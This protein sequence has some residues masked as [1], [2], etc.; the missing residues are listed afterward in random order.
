MFRL[1]KNSLS[2]LAFIFI[3]SLA[4]ISCGGGGGGSSDS[5][6]DE[7]GGGN[8]PALTDSEAVT[9]DRDDLVI[10]Y[11]SGDSAA[12]VT[13]SVTLAVSGSNGT[14]V[15]WASDN[16]TVI[17]IN[18]T[19]SRPTYNDGE[20]ATVTVTLTATI[21]KNGESDTKTFT[22]TVK[23]ISTS[24]TLSG[25]TVS[26]GILQP[27]FNSS[28]T[29][30]LDAPVPFSDSATP[31]YNDTQSASITATA[32]NS[33]A[34]ITINSNTVGSGSAYTM[35]NLA[36]GANTATIVVTAEDGVTNAT[37]VVTVYRA[38]PVFKTGQTTSYATGDDGD[39]E[40]GVSWP[41][42]RFT[43]N[44]NGTM[45]DNMTGLVWLK[46]LGT[47][48]CSWENGITYCE[49]L[50]TGGNDW[51]MPNESEFRSLVHYG[52]SQP[53]I[54]L[55]DQ[56]FSN[57]QSAYYWSSTTSA[58]DT[59]N[60]YCI[61]YYGGN[62]SYTES[63]T[64]LTW[65][66][67][68]PVCAESLNLPVSGQTIEYTTG[69]DGT[70]K[71]GVAFPSTRFRDNGDGTITD[72]MTGLM[73]MKNPNNTCGTVNSQ[74]ALFYVSLLNNVANTNNC[75]YTDWRVPNI[76][77][78]ETLVNY[79]QTDSSV[80][81]KSQGFE[82]IKSNAYWSS[83]SFSARSDHTWVVNFNSGYGY[84]T[85]NIAT[86]YVWPVRGPVQ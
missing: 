33:A 10:V 9:E 1:C 22:L 47:S 21:S 66:F 52:Q 84:Y 15:S 4:I 23:K 77:E 60:V 85:P 72:N 2:R 62:E 55:K 42:I 25:L 32:T 83:T 20:A 44:D 73:W 27:A 28:I 63:K 82:N 5:P 54:W 61:N 24:A 29:T 53:D 13:Q 49:N 34:T 65:H 50:S 78:L 17:A 6:D 69:D 26:K 39:L 80:W 45:T 18:G 51:R 79:S 81:L 70:Y 40:T 36:V 38:V 19:V 58:Q 68:W 11:G 74:E 71:K 16:T 56:G 8:P 37:Y 14:T 41:A 75:G 86:N 67:I 12:S 64:S 57:V 48:V 3:F 43:D 31:A 59:N 35:N 30:Y 7:P 46:S 76:N